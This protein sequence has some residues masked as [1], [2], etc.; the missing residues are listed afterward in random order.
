MVLPLQ[1]EYPDG[2]SLACKYSD[3]F[4]VKGSLFSYSKDINFSSHSLLELNCLS[5][6]LSL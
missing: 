3:A 5:H 6:S 1:L 2:Y 4:T